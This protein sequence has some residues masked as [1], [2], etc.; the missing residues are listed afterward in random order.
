MQPDIALTVKA[1]VQLLDYIEEVRDSI[2]RLKG[3][4]YYNSQCISMGVRVHRWVDQFSKSLSQKIN[5]ARMVNEIVDDPIKV[6]VP[7]S[8]LSHYNEVVILHDALKIRAKQ[9]G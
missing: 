3:E 7:E 1:A 4:S 9:N 2:I 8:A 5:N 6:Y